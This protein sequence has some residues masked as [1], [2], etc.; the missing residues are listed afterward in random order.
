MKR[1]MAIVVTAVL[2]VAGFS[3]QTANATV[4]IP[5]YVSFKVKGLSLKSKIM[6]AKQIK[7]IQKKVKAN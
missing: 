5:E 7:F 6:T 4:D 2:V 1:I 3:V